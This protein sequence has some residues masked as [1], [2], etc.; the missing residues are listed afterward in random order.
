MT[1]VAD[2]QSRVGRCDASLARTS[3]D[4]RTAFESIRNLSGQQQNQVDSLNGK[5]SGLENKLTQLIMSFDTTTTDQSSKIRAVEGDSGTAIARLDS[6]YAGLIEDLRSSVLATRN[7]SETERGKLENQ[8]LAYME[9]HK[10][11]YENRLVKIERYMEER[12]AALEKRIDSLE[13]FRENVVHST[14]R[15]EDR[16]K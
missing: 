2:L 12:L 14:E 11:Y 16:Q 10:Q 4:M 15:E 8:F 6:K 1:S 13:A 9:S 7:W 5:I 3:A